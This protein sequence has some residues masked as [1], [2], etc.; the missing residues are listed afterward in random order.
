MY[1]KSTVNV[2]QQTKSH[3]LRDNVKKIICVYYPIASANP[4]NKS[5][6]DIMQKQPINKTNTATIQQ[7]D[8]NTEVNFTTVNNGICVFWCNT[9]D[10]NNWAHRSPVLV[11]WIAISDIGLYISE[12]HAIPLLK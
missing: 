8:F 3:Y 12:K 10:M 11:T 2:V 5:Q 9:R 7:N 6:P 4:K 1:C